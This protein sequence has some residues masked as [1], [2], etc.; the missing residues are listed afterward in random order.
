MKDVIIIF[1]DS[2]NFKYILVTN[3][4]LSYPG[5][6]DKKKMREREA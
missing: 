5:V 1:M 2:A 3:G 6:G 4:K